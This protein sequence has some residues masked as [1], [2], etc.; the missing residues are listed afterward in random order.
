MQQD[1][2]EMTEAQTLEEGTA[3]AMVDK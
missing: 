3:A 2:T 1:Q